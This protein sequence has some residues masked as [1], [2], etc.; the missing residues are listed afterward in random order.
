MD[1]EESKINKSTAVIMVCAAFF[2][3][4]IQFLLN[5]IPG[6]GWIIIWIIDAIVWL[7]FYVWFRSRGVT[8]SSSRK[9]LSLGVGFVLELIPFI[10]ALPAWTLANIM[11][12]STTWAEEKAVRLTGSSDVIAKIGPSSSIKERFKKAA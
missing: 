9:S 11:V 10:N 2:I 4:I 7:T 1:N 12:I 6:P 5:F 3:D 8:F